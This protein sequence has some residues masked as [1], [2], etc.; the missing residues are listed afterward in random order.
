VLITDEQLKSPWW[1]LNNLYY[2]KDK[3]GRN[4]QFKLNAAQAKLFHETWYCN[5]ILK[6]RQLGIS[7]YSCILFLDQCLFNSNKACGIIAQTR[8]DSENLF[9][10]VKWAYDCLPQYIKDAMPATVD[11]ARELVFRNGSSIRVGTSM[12][13]STFQYLHLSEYGKICATDPSKAEEIL[14]GSLNTV[15]PGQY[16]FI[17]STAEGKSGYFY[18]LC[19]KAQAIQESGQPLTELDYKFHF[20]PWWV[21]PAYKIGSPINLT[22]SDYDYFLKLKSQSIELTNEQKYWYALK[23]SSQQENMKREY[24]STSDEAWEQSTEGFY[25]AKVLQQCRLERRICHVPYD[26]NLKVHTA[27]DLGFNDYTTIFLFQVYGKEVRLIE[28]IEGNNESLAYWI[29]LIQKKPYDYGI[30]LAPH[31]I[32]VR[33]YSTG[34]SRI[35]TARKL[36]LNFVAVPKV[37]IIPGID[38]VRSLMPRCWFD[39]DKCKIGISRLENYRMEWNSKFASWG[40]RPLH[41]ENSHGSDSMRCLATGLHIITGRR[42]PEDIERDRIESLKDQSGMLPGSMFYEGPQEKRRSHF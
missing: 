37:E 29:N 36:G 1:R 40:S 35:D 38:A 34:Y 6:A 2:I 31:D 12:R 17:E 21:D 14:T 19:K 41:D 20:F 11:S 28:Y 32:K 27:W 4:I 15:A 22:Q 30:H 13:G 18:D 39:K 25:Y 8:E 24:P 3:Q 42:T 26:D 7:T 9:K 33:E 16:I 10:K 5:I 23:A